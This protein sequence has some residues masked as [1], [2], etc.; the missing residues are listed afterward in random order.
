MKPNV[1]VRRSR[2]RTARRGS[3]PDGIVADFP[4]TYRPGY[5]HDGASSGMLEADERHT[6]IP[7]TPAPRPPAARGTPDWAGPRRTRW[8]SRGIDSIFSKARNRGLLADA[9]AAAAAA[10]AARQPRLRGRMVRT[11]HRRHHQVQDRHVHPHGVQRQRGGPDHPAHGRGCPQP[12]TRR[13][14]VR[15]VRAVPVGGVVGDRHVRRFDRGSSRSAEPPQ[16][17]LAAHLRVCCST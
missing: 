14:D 4:C 9:V 17:G 6:P 2:S 12:R 3:P 7:H 11:R 5:A 1:S 10:R 8:P 13:R 16:P 15:R